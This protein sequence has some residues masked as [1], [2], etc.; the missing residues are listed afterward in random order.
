[1]KKRKRFNAHSLYNSEIIV[2]LIKILKRRSLDNSMLGQ[3]IVCKQWSYIKY[4]RRRIIMYL[5]H[6]YFNAT[7][8]ENENIG[9]NLLKFENGVFFKVKILRYEPYKYSS[10][11]GSGKKKKKANL[12]IGQAQLL[13]M[14]C[15]KKIYYI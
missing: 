4:Y 5:M 2:Q 10:F 14:D 9:I 15:L 3:Q 8:C 11:L 12:I 13:E 7:L 6:Q 1:M